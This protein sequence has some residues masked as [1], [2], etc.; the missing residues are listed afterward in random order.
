MQT[1]KYYPIEIL[2]WAGM[3]DSCLDDFIHIYTTQPELIHSINR[4][5]DNALMIA[6][7]TGNFA[8]AQY[9]IDNTDIDIQ[10]RNYEGNALMIACKYKQLKIAQY[11]VENTKISL[12]IHDQHHNNLFH[13]IAQNGLDDIFETILKQRKR[14]Q[15]F[16]SNSENKTPFHFLIDSYA[17][18]KNYYLYELFLSKLQKKHLQQTYIHQKNILDYMFSLLEKNPSQYS[19]MKSLIFLMK[20]KLHIS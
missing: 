3:N 10:H 7:R 15:L 2:H 12:T 19:Y 14:I 16:E 4:Y 6:C 9:I 1:E 17:F 5:Q 18:H 13:M 20:N 11:L 8:I